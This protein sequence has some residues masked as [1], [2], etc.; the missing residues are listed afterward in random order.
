MNYTLQNISLNGIGQK[1]CN[2]LAIKY[3][4]NMSHF[5]YIQSFSVIYLQQHAYPASRQISAL[6]V[7][8]LFLYP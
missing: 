2:S 4:K 5:W 7:S 3:F 1:V 8:V 6:R